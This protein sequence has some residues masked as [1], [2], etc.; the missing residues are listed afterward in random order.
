M[1][2]LFLTAVFAAFSLITVS[3]QEVCTATCT[4]EKQIKGICNEVYKADTGLYFISQPMGDINPAR[5][6]INGGADPVLAAIDSA[7][8]GLNLHR[9]YMLKHRIDLYINCEG[10]VVH[11][12]GRSVNTNFN[13]TGHQACIKLLDEQFRNPANGWSPATANGEKIDSKLTLEVTV[14]HR[15]VKSYRVF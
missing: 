13:Q 10:E 9:R 12:L 1:K 3:A 6:T 8:T 5:A 11:Q 4:Y 14:R 7:L 15:K 2:Y